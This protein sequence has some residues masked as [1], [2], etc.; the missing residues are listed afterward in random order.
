MS[1]RKTD[2]R[3]ITYQLILAGLTAAFYVILT[4]FSAFFNLAYGPIQFRIS[5]AMCILPA[6][7]PSSIAGLTV[8]CIISNFFNPSPMMLIDVLVGSTATLLAA[9]LGRMLRNI[10]FRG[11]PWLLPL[12]AVLINAVA[13]GLELTF[14]VEGAAG[15]WIVAAEVALGQVVCCYG[16]GLSLYV[17]LQRV[18]FAKLAQKH[19]K[20]GSELK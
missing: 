18:G 9:V 15:F 7:F 5:E 1:R 20:W 6:F 17:C 12:P 4:I 2:R 11:I 10:R 3:Y 14:F 13:V 19:S 8:G 16:I